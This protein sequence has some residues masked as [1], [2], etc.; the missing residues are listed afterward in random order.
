MFVPLSPRQSVRTE[1]S[2]FEGGELL[3]HDLDL[4]K[5]LLDLLDLARRREG[6]FGRLTNNSVE[7]SSSVSSE[8]FESVL[9][10]LRR[11][12]IL[13]LLDELGRLDVESSSSLLD[14][15][16]SRGERIEVEFG[17]EVE[18]FVDV[19]DP[20]EKRGKARD[21]QTT[22]EGDASKNTG[23]WMMT[24]TCLGSQRARRRTE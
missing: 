15:G 5:N 6:E 2:R 12:E 14:F 17:V 21:Q 18:G 7:S 1:E 9:A 24:L 3:V 13:Q 16:D 10:A 22:T 19:S 20:D 11:G 23:E 4:G 8:R